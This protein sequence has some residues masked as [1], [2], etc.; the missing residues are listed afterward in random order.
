MLRRHETP[1]GNM[2]N[3]V[4]Q[5]S[6]WIASVLSGR[7]GVD[8]RLHSER[9]F[10]HAM[11]ESMPGVVYFYDTT[12]RF[13]RWNR[14]FER[15][16][17]YSA[18]EIARMHPLDFFAGEHKERVAARIAEVFEQG[19][20]S[21]EAPFV[22]RDG[23]SHMYFFT[24]RRVEFEDRVCLIGAGI[25][26]AERRRVEDR[27]A[28]SE[29]RYRELVELANS[30][31][32]RWAA[33]GRILFL[34]EFGLRFFG[35]RAEE[36]TGRHV[37]GTLVPTLESGGR[38]LQQLMTDICSTP[39]NHSENLNENMRR[40]GERVWISWTNRIVRDESGRVIELL[41]VGTDVTERMRHEEKLRDLEEQIRRAQKLEAIGQLAGGVAH[42][43]N[44]ILAA[45]LGNIQLALTDTAAGHPARQS[46]EEIEKAS[47]RA[48]GLVRQIL[49]FARHQ[50]QERRVTHLGPI[51]EEAARF[52]RSTL[53]AT[54][55]LFVQ[56]DPA[57]PPVRADATQ[58]YQAV[59]NLCTNAGHAL[60]E[61]PG[62]IEVRVGPVTLDEGA[63]REIVGLAPG[64]FVCVSVA[65]TGKGMDEATLERIFEPFFTTRDTGR[66]TGLGLSVVHGVMQGHAGAITVASQPGLGTTF[67]LYFPAA[68]GDAQPTQLESIPSRGS[69]ERILYIDDEESLV[70]LATRMLERLGYRVA[71]FTRADAALLA[72]QEDPQGFDLVVTDLNMPGITG[73]QVAAEVMK[74]RPDLPVVLCSGHVTDELREVARTC[75]IREVF[76]KPSTIDEFSQAI[77]RLAATI[78]KPPRSV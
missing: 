28:E 51:I 78:D 19:E 34:N 42:D 54:V 57:T 14:N 30:I 63:A 40:D 38:D 44:N 27:L 20:A 66:G 71:G 11:I 25:D 4:R 12:G 39:E 50:P 59:A 13:L 5:L 52:Q 69:G 31:I 35:Y 33:D 64:K 70:L 29:Q 37:I 22:A 23:T 26:V 67:K 55:D 3:A 73:L 45:I 76:Y 46:L 1:Q 77:H 24:G 21:I 61:G 2:G 68:I 17:G 56:V 7:S 62:R 72:I 75:G 36:I 41:S 74:L 60:S 8:A 49:T 53:P 6:G 47:L 65:D 58:V 9:L 43:F 15:V 16:S 48:R 18:D 32:L 10:S